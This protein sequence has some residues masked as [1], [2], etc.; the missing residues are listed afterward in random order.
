V[1]N[2]KRTLLDS[3][4]LGEFLLFLSGH[5]ITRALLLVAGLAK[6]SV[7]PAEP[8]RDA[9]AKLAFIFYEVHPV[10]FA[11][12]HSSTHGLRSALSANQLFFF[13]IEVVLV[14]LVAIFHSS[15]VGILA[16]E[17]HVIGQF[18]HCIILQFVVESRFGV[19]DPFMLMEILKLCSLNCLFDDVLFES[20]LLLE[21][22]LKGQYV[23]GVHS[24]FTVWAVEEAK[25][26]TRSVV[27]IFDEARNAVEMENMATLQH[28]TW[29][30]SDLSAVAN[31]AE[32]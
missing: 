7:S 8:L 5:V 6:M 11:I 22:F 16:L 1:C 9:A 23:R 28:N 26:D 25:Y 32:F 30:L 12:L 15:E 19:C 20:L 3:W 4:T 29:F 13:E 2:L 17:T 21:L 31:R 14:G 24:L 27:S 18:G 10:L